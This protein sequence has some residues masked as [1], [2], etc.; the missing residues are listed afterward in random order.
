MSETQFRLGVVAIFA[1]ILLHN[2]TSPNRYTIIQSGAPA[3]Q[4]GE[5]TVADG[6]TGRVWVG[7]IDVEWMEI[8]VE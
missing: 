3:K 6:V 8:G 5:V 1:A 4:S 2:L 7:T